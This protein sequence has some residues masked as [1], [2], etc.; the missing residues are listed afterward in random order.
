MN[1]GAIA[2]SFSYRGLI[3]L[4]CAQNVQRFAI[5]VVCS[6]TRDRVNNTNKEPRALRALCL[7][8]CLPQLK[9]V[10]L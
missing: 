1:A 3:G 9:E 10:L 4:L 5:R 8:C 7:L 6:C 2:A